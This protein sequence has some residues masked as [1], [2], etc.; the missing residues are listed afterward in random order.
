MSERK[1]LDFSK[2][3]I[4]ADFYFT[5]PKLLIW[6]DRR[7]ELMTPKQYAAAIEALG[8][9]QRA[10]GAFLGVDERTS[11][12]WVLGESAI[13]ESAAKLLRLMVHLKI[14]PEDVK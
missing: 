14:T 6:L 8:M 13:P 7:R 9:S 11:R 3:E 2:V 10:A 5:W 1:N 4:D 12:R